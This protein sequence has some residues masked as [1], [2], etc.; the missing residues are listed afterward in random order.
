MNKT[1]KFCICILLGCFMG[2]CDVYKTKRCQSYVPCYQ[3]LNSIRL[4]N[5]D[6]FLNCIV[7]RPGNDI[8]AQEF[9]LFSSGG[10]KDEYDRLCAKHND[11][12]Y[13]KYRHFLGNIANEELSYIDKDFTGIFITSDKVYDSA[14]PAGTSLSDI[15]RFMSWSPYRY[16][17]SGYSNYY[18]YTPISLSETFRTVM[19]HYFGGNCFHT[20]TDATCFP[21]DKMTN[22][23]LREDLILLGHDSPWIIGLL[24][25][26]KAPEYDG[27]QT[28]TVKMTTDSGEILENIIRITL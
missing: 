23:L 16:I 17:K 6:E 22:E 7:I 27:E 8:L 12:N 25:F 14:H 2:S 13:N 20:E 24:Y 4:T 5:D 1:V 10:E 15:V 21:V 19:P 3:V 9:S 28:F 26:E 11:L 18:H